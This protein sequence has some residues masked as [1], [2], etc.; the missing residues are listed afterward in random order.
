MA[1]AGRRRAI[2]L[3]WENSAE[4]LRHLYGELESCESRTS[5]QRKRERVR[6]ARQPAPPP[7]INA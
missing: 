4:A 2:A 7:P 3:S 1:L 5:N 6:D